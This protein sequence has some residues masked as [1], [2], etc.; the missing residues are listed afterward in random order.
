MKS[1]VKN[2]SLA[3]ANHSI[4]ITVHTLDLDE[5]FLTVEKEGVAY[6]L[7]LSDDYA[8]LSVSYFNQDIGYDEKV[9]LEEEG[10][11][12]VALANKI[13]DIMN[14][15]IDEI[16]KEIDYLMSLDNF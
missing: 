11:E 14:S 9:I 3:L 8:S 15:Q 1:V 4:Q 7:V 6:N 5:A 13:A 16:K 10:F 2:L 12:T